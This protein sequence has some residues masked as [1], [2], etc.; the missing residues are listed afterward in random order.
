MSNLRISQFSDDSNFQL[1]GVSINESQSFNIKDSIFLLKDLNESINRNLSQS[2][3]D[4]MNCFICLRPTINPLSCPK[5]NN[6]ACKKCLELY[7]GNETLKKCPLCKQDIK[8]TDMRE[9]KIIEDIENILNKEDTKMNKINELSKLIEDKKK[10][11]ENQTNS[12]NNIV[13]RIFKYQETLEDYKKGYQTFFNDCKKVVE[14]AF[15]DY[16][17]KTEELINSLLSFNKVAD[18]SI[19]KYNDINKK[20]QNDYYNSNDKIKSLINEVQSM[21]R[22]H[23][24]EKNNDKTE[25]FLQ[26]P[27]K[28]VPLINHYK[29]REVQLE[30][31]NDNNTVNTFKSS[32]YKLGRYQIKY[33]SSKN[34][35]KCE[36][37]FTLNNEMNACFL[38]TQNKEEDNNIHKCFPMKLS[39][40]DGKKYIFECDISLDD[41]DFEKKEKV[42]ISTEVLIFSV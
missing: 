2:V 30:K 16:Y 5:C 14:K 11:W 37:I 17:K 28:L 27:I 20:N 23:F 26:A 40:N 4:L 33:Y 18:D 24:N 38:I 34:K 42:K 35:T 3:I 15:E 12:I 25:K 31:F 19:K 10:S 22:K 9:N 36:F 29:I 21:E 41:L 13:E 32:H 1:L 8:F 7:F 6:F 39:K